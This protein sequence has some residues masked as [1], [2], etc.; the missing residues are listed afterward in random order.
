MKPASGEWYIGIELGSKW[1]QI[2]AYH[3]KMTEPETK[4]TV[5]GAELYRIPT[6]ICKRKLTG[7]WCF[8]EEAS[9]IAESKEGIY[10]DYLLDRALKGETVR[11]DKD[12]QAEDLLLVFLRKVLRIAL[13]AKGVEGVT[14]CVFSIPEVTEEWVNLLERMA[15]ALEFREE[16]ITI[17]DHRES[18][19]AYVVCQDPGLWQYDSMLFSCNGEEIWMK[20]LSCNKKTK[21]QIAEVEEVCLGKLPEDVKEWDLAFARMLQDGMSGRIVSSVYLIGSGFE[22][23]W[24]KESLKVICRGRRAFQGKNLY[25]KGACYSGMMEI[26]QEQAD[27]VYFCEYK[28]EEHTF[29]KVIKGDETYFYPL[30]EAGKN[31]HQVKKNLRILLEGE[32]L[33]ELWVQ[34][35]GSREA[36]IESLELSELPVSE[37]E[38]CRLALSLFSGEEGSILL[39]IQ[40]MGWGELHPGSG[41]E[42]EYEIG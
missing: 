31:R 2:S 21:P 19:Y 5:T 6:A 13:P 8:G 42:W 14:K 29:I 12:Y 36:K 3:G 18:F 17:Q 35:P 20:Q 26:H 16:Q 34:K 39:N 9:R 15:K 22:G 11:M 10:V 28:I 4:S 37:T 7:K 27:T 32:P 33:L 23:D 25:T 30:L 40:D 24:M 1:T 41:R 38:R